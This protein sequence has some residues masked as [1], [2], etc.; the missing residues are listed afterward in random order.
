ML[1]SEII[2]QENIKK[3]LI[4]S[5]DSGRIPHAQLFLAPTGSGALPMAIAYAQYILCSNSNGENDTGDHACNVKF[6]NLAHP[7]LHFAFPVTTNEKVKKHPTSNAFMEDWRLFVSGH[8]YGSLFNWYQQLGIENKQ[9]QIGVDEAE[10]IVKKLTLKA[11]EG[12]FKVMIIWMADKMNVSASNKLLKLIEEPPAKTVF[13]LIAED[14]EQILKTITSRC[15][16]LHFQPL[17]EQDITDRLLR[18]YQLDENQA[19][20]IAHQSH[21]SWN[22]ALH[23]LQQDDNEIAFEKWFITWVRTAFK[24]KGDASVVHDLITWSEEIAK[25]GRETQKRFLNYCSQFFRQAMLANYGAGSLVYLETTTRNFDLSKFAPFIH[26]ANVED[27]HKAIED[28]S[29][30]IE[31]NGNAKII[32]LDLSMQLTRYLHKKEA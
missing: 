10:D 2:G 32:L 11:Y 7:D 18:D 3:H 12:G 9:G 21:G 26:G 17:A 8:P 28:A 24:A 23:M 22:K 13:I 5:A 1:F 14:E 25:T 31:R 20:R 6:E 30:H 16:K 29:Y 27:I 15:Q 4:R 19:M